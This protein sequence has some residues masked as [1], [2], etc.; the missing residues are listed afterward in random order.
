MRVLITGATGFIGKHLSM[1][2]LGKGCKVLGT[3]YSGKQGINGV[4]IVKCDITNKVEVK[5]I[6]SSFNPELIFHLAAQSWPEKSWQEPNTTMKVNIEGIINLYE[7]IK[8]LN[9]DPLVFVPCSAAEYGDLE[10]EEYPVKEDHS[11]MPINPYGLSK[12]IQSLLSYQYYKNFN[13]RSIVLRLFN[14]TGAYRANGVCSDFVKRAVMIEKGL[15]EPVLNVGN[16]ESKRAITDVRDVINAIWLL[17]EKGKVGE[18]YNICAPNAY[19]IREILNKVLAITGINPQIRQD[20]SLLRPADE[21]IIIGDTTK[22]RQHTGWE[23]KYDI[24]TTLKD[25]VSE[26][27]LKL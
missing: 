17:V 19:S 11:L 21:K 24:D 22:L 13:I 7:S 10:P 6:L 4:D 14:A 15:H 3:S 26:W 27:R 8:D 9:L 20:P 25:M 23:P 5:E 16:L 1:F 2:L 12:V 18:T